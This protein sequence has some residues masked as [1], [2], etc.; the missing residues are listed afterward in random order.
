M[1]VSVSVWTDSVGREINN[2]CTHLLQLPTPNISR[3]PSDTLVS[4][5]DVYVLPLKV[6]VSSIAISMLPIK[7]ELSAFDAHQ[8]SDRY[9]Y[10]CY[11]FSCVAPDFIA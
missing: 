7:A 11:W 3:E 2:C 5:S 4:E 9:N 1:S 10:Y 6:S 8:T